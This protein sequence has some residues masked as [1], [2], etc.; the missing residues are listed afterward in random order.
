M[1]APNCEVGEAPCYLKIQKLEVAVL[2][3]ND[4]NPPCQVCK[5]R[6]LMIP[7]SFFLPVTLETQG[8]CQPLLLL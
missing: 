6:D 8:K 5:S 2:Q 3:M 7:L 1:S 4:L